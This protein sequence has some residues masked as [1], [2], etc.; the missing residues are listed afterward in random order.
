MLELNNL[1]L[2][3]DALARGLFFIFLYA[4]L[5]APELK[6]SFISCFCI[7]LF[8]SIYFIIIFHGV[9]QLSFFL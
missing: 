7:C 2:F 6:R 8:S 9:T 4:V 1:N 3:L 5:V